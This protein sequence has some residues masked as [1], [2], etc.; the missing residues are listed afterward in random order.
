[1]TSLPKRLTRAP[2]RVLV[3]NAMGIRWTWS[4]TALRRSRISPS[5]RVDDSQRVSSPT[6]A[7]AS[8]TTAMTEAIDTT[9][10][11]APPW[12]MASTTRPAI[13]GVATA[14]SAPTVLIATNPPS[15]R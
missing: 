8:A 3:K 9:V 1:M 12:T 13:R 7:S 5:P 4:N 10:L 15:L 2:V 6:P 11:G 14:N